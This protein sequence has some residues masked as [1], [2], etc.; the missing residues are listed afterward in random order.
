MVRTNLLRDHLTNLYKW[1]FASCIDIWRAKEE[2]KN[3]N[4]T[5]LSLDYPISIEIHGEGGESVS[6]YILKRSA[7]FK[8]YLSTQSL[9]DASSVRIFGSLKSFLSDELCRR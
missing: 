5:S 6:E 2:E 4:R 7:D 8:S 9:G 1:S 3:Y